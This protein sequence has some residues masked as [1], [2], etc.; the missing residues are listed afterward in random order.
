MF[1]P[2]LGLLVMSAPV[3]GVITSWTRPARTCEDATRHSQLGKRCN[4]AMASALYPNPI[5]IV[6][7][8][9]GISKFNRLFSV[10]Q[11]HGVILASM[12]KD[13][14]DASR[15]QIGVC[16]E[17][18]DSQ[19][20]AD[21]VAHNERQ[22]ES[23]PLMPPVDKDMRYEILGATHYNVALR[24]GEAG[25]QSPA[26]DL[27]LLKATDASF[28]DACTQGHAWIV[29][30]SDLADSLKEDICTWRNQDQNENQTL[31]DGEIIRQACQVVTEFTSATGGN[32]ATLPLSKVVNAMAM[33]NTL[34]LNPS[35][36]G[37]FARWVCQMAEEKQTKLV[38]VFL[39]SWT[40]NVNSKELAIPHSFFDNAAKTDALKQKALL[41]LHLA[42][43]MYT[44]EGS[45]VKTRPQPDLCGFIS[46]GDLAT[47]DRHEFLAQLAEKNP[48]AHT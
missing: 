34:R 37:G 42:L 32:M 29:L 24:C 36:L 28:A 23:S 39:D 14:H 7:K 10:Q 11:V 44:N 46:S 8:L 38:H 6:P 45:Q 19:Q 41:R 43:A 27:G 48:A 33:K 17:L 22:S 13:G 5:R 12:V 16:V 3:A 26:G 2:P 25:M 21:L 4:E 31:T 30:P 18:Q 40:I 9:L 35:V 47:L 1:G 20:K 15:A